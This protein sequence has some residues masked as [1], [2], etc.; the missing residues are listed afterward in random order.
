VSRQE[1]RVEEDGGAT[2]AAAAARKPTLRPRLTIRNH[3]SGPGGGEEPPFTT[4]LGAGNNKEG[5]LGFAS[6]LVAG[7]VG[8]VTGYPVRHTE[9]HNAAAA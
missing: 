1:G 4:K 3:V 7:I 9:T 2:A 8:V 6:G 5:L